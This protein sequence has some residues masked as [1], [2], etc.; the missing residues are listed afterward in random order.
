M[1]KIFE[2]TTL[3]G[4]LQSYEVI[5][6]SPMTFANES[7]GISIK[8]LTRK[9]GDSCLDE[10]AT[11]AHQVYSM[12][13]LD[14]AIKQYPPKLSTEHDGERFTHAEIARP[15][16]LRLIY[17]ALPLGHVVPI[18]RICPIEGEQIYVAEYDF[19]NARLP[20]ERM[21]FSQE[22]DGSLDM[23]FAGLQ[24]FLHLRNFETENEDYYCRDL[25]KSFIKK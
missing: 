9:N 22:F 12:T 11:H 16:R 18:L 21:T 15:E 17:D 4:R 6:V 24:V 1:A 20:L 2:I 7:P 23:Q 10:F 19:K 8:N 13:G 5:E 25:K 3:A 14:D